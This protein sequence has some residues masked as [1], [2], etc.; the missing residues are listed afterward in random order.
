MIDKL[1]MNNIEKN[2]PDNKIALL[3]SGGVDS[4]SIGFSAHRLG[5]KVTAYSFKTD[6]HN[7]YDYNKAE[8]VANIMGWNFIGTTVPVNNLK[9]DFFK[10]LDNYNCEKKTQFECTYP[11]LYVYPKIKEKYVLSGLGADG[12]HGLSKKVCIHF[13]EPKELFDKFRLDYFHNTPNIGGVLQQKM[14]AKNYNKTYIHPYLWCKEIEDFFLSKSW[15]ELNKPQQKKYIRIS[16]EKEF[17][18]VGKVKK[19]LNLQLDSQVNQIFESLLDD[20]DINFKNRS[21]VMD[22]CRD[23]VLKRKDNEL[24]FDM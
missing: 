11:F 13:K 8:E 16:F 15:E 4:M 1:L 24:S 9:E 6:K 17:A 20:E 3:L 12:Y 21:R 5:K 18:K 10:L 14:L 19:H 2:V 7:S 23:W 22:I